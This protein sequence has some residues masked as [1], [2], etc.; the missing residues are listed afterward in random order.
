MYFGAGLKVKSVLGTVGRTGLYAQMMKATRCTMWIAS[1]PRSISSGQL[2]SET[3]S[4][5]FPE[6]LRSRWM[7]SRGSN[8][9]LPL[10]G[11]QYVKLRVISLRE[12]V[13][14]GIAVGS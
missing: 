6:A 11:L 14:F 12:T 8:W 1:T 9:K 5:P 4:Q 10:R 7:A 2:R 13:A 3:L